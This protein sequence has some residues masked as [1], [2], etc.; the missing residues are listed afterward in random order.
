MLLYL[1]CTINLSMIRKCISVTHI[2]SSLLQYDSTLYKLRNFM[3]P[4]Q[5]LKFTF[6]AD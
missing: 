5:A 6:I 2:R 3:L 1:K 4:M